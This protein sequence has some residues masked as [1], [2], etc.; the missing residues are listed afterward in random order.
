MRVPISGVI[1][2]AYYPLYIIIVLIPFTGVGIPGYKGDVWF[3]ER[4]ALFERYTLESLLNQSD[5][6]FTLWVVFRPEEK[7]H[8]EGEGTEAGQALRA[9]AEA[10]GLPL[11][12]SSSGSASGAG[13]DYGSLPPI[14]F[15]DTSAA[16]SAAYARAKDQTG[17]NTRAALTAL[18]DQLAGSQLLGSGQEA[19]ATR[20]IVGR[21]QG[22]L[23]EVTREQA[24]QDVGTAERRAGQEYQGR[25][26]QRGQDINAA[27]QAAARQ[28]QVLQGL[29]SVINSAGIL[30]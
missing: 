3:K 10:S 9:L 23:N 4:I 17:L 18:Q 28:Q 1:H 21:G 29:L 15:P 8:T 12:G 27:Q 11:L 22:G 14:A 16:T 20:D 26:T 19:A 25:I 5:K 2:V 6:D 13:A 7:N 24:I 30:Y